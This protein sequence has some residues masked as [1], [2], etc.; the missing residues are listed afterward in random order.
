[1]ACGI[2]VARRFEKYCEMYDVRLLIMSRCLLMFSG[3]CGEKYVGELSKA[4]S[5]KN[6]FSHVITNVFKTNAGVLHTWAS[7][8]S[9]G[10]ALKSST[11]SNAGTVAKYFKGKSLP[12]FQTDKSLRCPCFLWQ[13][14]SCQLPWY[15]NHGAGIYPKMT[16]W[17]TVRVKVGKYHIPAPWSPHLGWKEQT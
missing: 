6:S 2:W 10:V 1:M 8:V 15:A 5:L 17:W 12:N 7:G 13:F 14:D 9:R 11:I 4:V 16:G 3:Q